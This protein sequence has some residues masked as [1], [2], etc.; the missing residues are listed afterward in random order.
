MDGFIVLGE[1]LLRHELLAES[2]SIFHRWIQLEVQLPECLYRKAVT[3]QSPGL[4]QPWG[5]SGSRINPVRVAPSG[6][7]RVAV[8]GD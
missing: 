2:V 6:R 4:L 7:N 5:T 1:R 3:S 8:V